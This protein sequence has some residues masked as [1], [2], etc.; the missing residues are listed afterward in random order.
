MTSLARPLRRFFGP[1]LSPTEQLWARTQDGL[2]LSIKRVSDNPTRGAVM[3][4]H[5]L[6]GSSAT[7]HFPERSLASY[8][9]A[10]GFDCYVAELRGSGDSESP[11]GGWDT[12]D[13]LHYDIPA[14]LVRI[15]EVAGERQLSW[16]GH[17]MGGVLLYCYGI[18]HPKAP[19]VRGI[20]IG[21]AL[22]YTQGDSGFSQFLF[23]KRWLQKLRWSLP[24]GT[25]SHTLAPL[26]GRIP[27]SFERF[28]VNPKNIE[29]RMLRRIYALAFDSIP[30]E[31]LMNLSSTFEPQGL[32]CRDGSFSYHAHAAD[33]GIET[34]AIGGSADAQ[35]PPEAIV[36][37]QAAIGS[38]RK[39]TVMFGKRFG[40][41]EDYGHWDLLV[42]RHAAVEVWPQIESY[43]RGDG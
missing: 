16:V 34:L 6:G 27:T 13:Y 1:G 10:C 32:S 18:K 41:N 12:D 2:M 33:Y 21:S 14:L 36:A 5:G 28:N 20:T 35:C 37:T 15:C 31:L 17:S 25:L 23:L 43:L 39:K 4:L 3:L 19:I 30:L 7:F 29:P 38:R 11:K 42:G 24:Y 8:L 22:D 40:H 26:L 9:S